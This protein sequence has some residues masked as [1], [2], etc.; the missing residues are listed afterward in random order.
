MAA[1]IV[2]AVI[3]ALVIGHHGG[4]AHANYRHGRACGKRGVNLF[5]S[6]ARGPLDLRARPVQD[7]DRSQALNRS[8]TDALPAHAPRV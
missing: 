6:S 8:G 5:W 1:L 2:I 3:A 7:T 4:H